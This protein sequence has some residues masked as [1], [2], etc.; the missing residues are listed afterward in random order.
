M[1]SRDG[2]LTRLGANAQV[3]CR[4]TWW[5]FLV[6]GLASVIFG[7]VAFLSPGLALFLLAMYFAASILVDGAFNVAG[8]LGHRGKD[9][10]WV[11]LLMGLLGLA[12]GGYALVNPPLSIVAF[13]YLV[14]IQAILLGVF[15][16]LLGYK[17]RRVTTR[18]WILYAAGALSALFG[19]FVFANP[20]AGGV[21][22]VY[23]IACWAVVVGSLKVWFGVKVKKLPGRL[24]DK[25]SALG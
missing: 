6:G 23:A 18:E 21:S 1:A 7:V 25:F 5:V 15:L 24:G 20:L 12:V 9:G 17:V 2:I 13:V 19:V 16:L 22:I 11:M 8:A 3:L 10:W 4:R 14:A